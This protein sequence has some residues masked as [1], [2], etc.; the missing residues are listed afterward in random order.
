MKTSSA[1]IKHH[2]MKGYGGMEVYLHALLS[3]ALDAVTSGEIVPWYL[4]E[5]VG[6]APE[7]V[8]TRWRKGKIP[9]PAGK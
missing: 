9:A 4:Q 8:W 6:W 3:S 5:E 1:L 7:P 2:A